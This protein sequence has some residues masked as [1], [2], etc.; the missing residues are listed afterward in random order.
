MD[1]LP[2]RD[3]RTYTVY[4]DMLAYQIWL[5]LTSSKDT[6]F[7]LVFGS[8]LPIYNKQSQSFVIYFVS[9]AQYPNNIPESKYIPFLFLVLQWL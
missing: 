3:L 5:L 1:H 6:L 4:F 2:D 9:T 8:R 7:L